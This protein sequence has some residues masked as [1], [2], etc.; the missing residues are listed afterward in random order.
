MTAQQM[1]HG[2]GV[3][4]KDAKAQ[5]KHEVMLAG[6]MTPNGKLKMRATEVEIAPG[7]Y[8]GDHLHYGP[9]IRQMLAGEL[10]LVNADTGQER[11]VRAGDYFDETGDVSIRP[12]NRSTVP[13]KFAIS[14]SFRRTWRRVRRCL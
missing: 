5:K 14:S 7:G 4:M 2:P 13:A 9:G 12:Y 8:I 1:S 3:E 6:F 11:V 10:T